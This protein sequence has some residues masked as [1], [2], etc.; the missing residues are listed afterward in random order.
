MHS[1]SRVF[2]SPAL[3]ASEMQRLKN[4][5]GSTSACGLPQA[6]SIGSAC[7]KHAGALEKA[8]SPLRHVDSSLREGVTAFRDREHLYAASTDV[9]NRLQEKRE[10]YRVVSPEV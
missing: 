10:R 8:A 7:Q 2:W 6:L 3:F 1:R 4:E 5:T 9:R